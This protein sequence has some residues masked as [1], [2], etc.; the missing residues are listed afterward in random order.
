MWL[1]S[2]SSTPSPCFN[3]ASWHFYLTFY[4]IL[5]CLSLSINCCSLDSLDHKLW[6]G[7][8]FVFLFISQNSAYSIFAEWVNELSPC[9]IKGSW[10]L[11]G[12][13]KV[14]L[15]TRVKHLCLNILVPCLRSSG[16]GSSSSTTYVPQRFPSPVRPGN[17]V[18]W[19]I[20]PEDQSQDSSPLPSPCYPANTDSWKPIFSMPWTA[21]QG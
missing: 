14:I 20:N 19:R 4:C 12:L 17:L 15:C 3:F 1:S 16:S 2:S 11:G 13:A 9:Y 18:P 6:E 10:G 7:R 8:D 5:I 21:R